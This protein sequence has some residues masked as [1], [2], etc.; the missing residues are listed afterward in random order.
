MRLARGLHG[1]AHTMTNRRETDKPLSRFGHIGA[2][3]KKM[4]PRITRTEQR[5]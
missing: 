4:T 2:L 3:R 1:P 5:T